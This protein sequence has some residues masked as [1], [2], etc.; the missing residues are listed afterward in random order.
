VNDTD[1]A[2]FTPEMAIQYFVRRQG[3]TVEE[4]G[5]APIVVVSWAPSV[6]HRMAEATGAEPAEN[7]LRAGRR[8][9]YTGR[10]GDHRVSFA[11]VGI[12]APATIADMEEMIACGART[13][14]GLGW[15]GSL[16][17]AAPV[18]TLLIPRECFREEGTSR[19]YISGDVTFEPDPGLY[20]ILQRTAAAGP[21]KVMSGP[22]WTTDAP[23]RELHS[24]IERYR[25]RGVVGVDMETSAMY[26][27]GRFRQVAVCNLLVVSDELWEAWRPAFRTPELKAATAQAQEVILNTVVDL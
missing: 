17:P 25:R 13:F 9:F 16:Q 24:T 26:A 19:H 8:A 5:V 3:I 20:D 22:H 2:R 15:A 6:I 7:W 21:A 18:G 12:G 14:L 4:M 27:L 11:E 1:G 23:Y 10:I